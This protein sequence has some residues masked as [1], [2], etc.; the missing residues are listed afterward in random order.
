MA[1]ISN[2]EGSLQEKWDEVWEHF[3]RLA[4]VTG[5]S[6]NACLGQALQVLDKIPTIPIES[7]TYQTWHKDGG[8]TSSL[9]ER[10]RAFHLLMRKL[11][12]HAHMGR[13]DDSSSDR[14]ASPAHSAG[15]AVPCSQ[16]HLPSSSCS[17]SRSPSPQC[18]H[19]AS[20]SSSVTSVYSN[21]TQ[22]GSVQ[23]SGPESGSEAD[24]ESQAGGDSGSEEGEDW[25]QG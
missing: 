3:C 23:A 4:D 25:W 9:G 20:H 7:Y 12:W 10:V 16:R 13:I 8:E 6:H 18:L 17:W 21:V 14:S 24:T 15:S 22:K 19:S 5:V 1:F 2:A 11:E